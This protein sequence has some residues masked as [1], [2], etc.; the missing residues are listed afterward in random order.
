M[1]SNA[2]SA[3]AQPAAGTETPWP[4]YHQVYLVLRQQ[5]R[6]GSFGVDGTIPSEMELGRQFGAS[7]ITIRKALERLEREGA[8]D[9]RPGRGTFVRPAAGN[10]HVNASLSGSIENLI[11]MGLQT[12][13]KVVSF[14]YVPAPPLA[15][16]VLG[17][18]AGA[19]VQRAVRVRSHDGRPFSHLTT[20]VPEDIG[21]LYDRADL[22]EKPL[23]L[24]LERSGIRIAA[25]EQTITA[26]L[27]EP[28]IARLLDLEPGEPLLS[29]T[30]VVRDDSGRSVEFITGHY[31]PD[32]YEHHMS[33]DRATRDD[34]NVW[35][36]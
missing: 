21:R 35:R 16:D 18:D 23:L 29:I 31:R 24:L 15:A 11:A 36:T 27:A 4:K 33:I 3:R 26:R 19:T 14:D 13:V 34:Q 9:R 1:T 30:R 28:E 17:L 7:R 22:L 6:D 5:I 2:N 25:A 12:Q 10:A 32:T 20:F 8:I